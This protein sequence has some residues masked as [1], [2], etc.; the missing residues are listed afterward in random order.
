M[1]ITGATMEQAKAMVAEILGTH[2]EAL[3]KAFSVRGEELKAGVTLTIKGSGEGVDIG[4][5]I[6]YETAAKVKDKIEKNFNEKQ[7]QLPGL[8]KKVDKIYSMVKGQVE[9]A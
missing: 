1:K 5:D 9:K 7:D 6:S 8:D 2:E 4:V 3:I